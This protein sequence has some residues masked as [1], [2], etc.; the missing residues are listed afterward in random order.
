TAHEI[1]DQ[2]IAE[3][4]AHINTQGNGVPVIVFNPLSW[5]RSDVVEFEAQLPGPAKQITVTNGAGKPA[6]SQLLSIDPET[7]RARFILFASTPAFGYK[8]YFLRSATNSAPLNS[9]LKA[10]GDT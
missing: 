4:A 6:Q 5:S 3:I 2:S 9:S 8:T 1:I 7:H 10:T